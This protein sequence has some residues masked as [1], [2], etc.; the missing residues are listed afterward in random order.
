MVCAQALKHEW[1]NINAQ[2]EATTEFEE[3]INQVWI[4]HFDGC[5]LSTI[6]FFISKC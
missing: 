1:L 2:C 5:M 3:G 4:D 6:V